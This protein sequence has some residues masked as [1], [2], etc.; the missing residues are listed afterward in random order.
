MSEISQKRGFAP[1]ATWLVACAG[2]YCGTVQGV[3][4]RPGLG[5]IQNLGVVPAHRGHEVTAA[6]CDGARSLIWQQAENRMHAQ[7]G[8]LVWLLGTQ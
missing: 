6:V 1:E 7:R 5:A 2:D 8:L 3:R 4:D